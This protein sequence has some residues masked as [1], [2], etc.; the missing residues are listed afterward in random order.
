[1]LEGEYHVNTSLTV[2]EEQ[3]SAFCGCCSPVLVV[4]PQE[5][6]WDL[7][8]FVSFPLQ[9]CQSSVWLPRACE[10]MKT[11]SSRWLTC[12]GTSFS[13]PLPPSP[14]VGG[15]Q[16]GQLAMGGRERCCASKKHRGLR[17]TEKKAWRIGQEEERKER[18]EEIPSG[19][20]E[21]NVIYGISEILLHQGMQFLLLLE[22]KIAE[23]CF[24]HS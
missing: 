8:R 13:L 1:M 11:A 14:F 18:M 19:C 2:S 16:A 17:L 6:V 21:Q 7:W 3:L 24:M 9:Q 4:Q 22:R 12:H 23:C 20:E 5:G 10:G 15:S